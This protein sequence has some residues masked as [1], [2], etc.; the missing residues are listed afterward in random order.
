MAAI[1]TAP[2]APRDA[3]Y[4]VVGAPDP[5]LPNS[6]TVDAGGTAA[7][8]LA[9]HIPAD[10]HSQYALLSG[11]PGQALNLSTLRLR[12]TG[13][14]FDAVL[15]AT[16]NPAATGDRALT[17]NLA[18]ANRLVK[19]AGNLD[20]T[21]TFTISAPGGSIQFNAAGNANLAVPLVGTLA[22]LDGAETLTQKTLTAPDVNGGAADS[23]TAFSLRDTS[24]AFDVSVVATSNPVITGN[25][26]L[27]LNLAD[28]NRSIKLAGNLDITGTFAKSG[29][30]PLQFDVTGV[31]LLTL[32]TS[33]TLST[34]DG[35]ETFTNKTLTA[36]DVNGGTA[37]AL[38]SLSIRD[39]SAAFDVTLRAT[40]SPALSS[41][42]ILT[43]NLAD[44]SRTLKL[45]GNLDV[46]GT[47]TI[48]APTGS[49]QLNTT[50]AGENAN[51]TVQT[52][53]GTLAFLSDITPG[54]TDH[55][56]LTGLLD[57][58]HTQYALLAGRAGGQTLTGGTAA[59]ENL[60]LRSTS[61]ATKGDI[62][63]GFGSGEVI[64]SKSAIEAALP[65]GLA[66]DLTVADASAEFLVT[67]TTGAAGAYAR[68]I[69]GNL[70]GSS[71]GVQLAFW[72]NAAGSFG[73]G[74]GTAE[75]SRW[76]TGTGPFVIGTTVA[77]PFVIGTNSTERARWLTTGEFAIGATSLVG[78]EQMLVR[79]STA[80]DVALYLDGPTSGNNI[81]G[82][83]TDGYNAGLRCA[84]E[85][86][87]AAAQTLSRHNYIDLPR[88]TVTNVTVTNAAVM[89][90]D[91]AAGTH[92]ATVG[93]TT[94]TTPGG[95]DAWVKINMNG[96]IHYV[97]AYLS[98]TA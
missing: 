20:I 3:A 56:A 33:G 76:G 92:E 30:D 61:H 45:G 19:L 18:D 73:L 75:L 32:P 63:I 83:T 31:T 59:S 9:A 46:T 55:G 24:G 43:L 16:S 51:V 42:R 13:A 62:R 94:K 28:G 29:T 86:R 81:T 4:G 39:T 14:A 7:A 27:T 11:R 22:T 95:V 37:D 65:F 78:A 82:A 26:S 17:V 54:V 35:I 74:A 38:T 58:D 71:R 6:A 96:T 53:P 98:T 64:S 41:A 23:L 52:G 48:S 85:Y 60:Y 91:A 36:P 5:R 66:A 49:I 77:V 87:A 90:F 44:A 89:R 12:D 68:A 10:D 72:E 57:D 34:L 47:F 50:G 84:P 21:G 79:H 25:H 97:P 2:G 1:L 88:P 15:Q 67:T 80:T 70:A 40:S 69:V 93:A 8:L